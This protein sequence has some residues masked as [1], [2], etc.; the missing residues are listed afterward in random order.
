ME[1]D[2]GSIAWRAAGERGAAV[3]ISMMADGGS[4]ADSLFLQDIIQR[5]RKRQ[6]MDWGFIP[7]TGFLP[8]R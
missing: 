2:S 3:M 6:A 5:N 1:V 4:G 8:P 7:K